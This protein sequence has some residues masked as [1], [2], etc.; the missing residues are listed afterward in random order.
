M[1]R[2]H[3]GDGRRWGWVEPSN[4]R[5]GGCHGL[6]GVRSNSREQQRALIQRLS[7]A[8]WRQHTPT[9]CEKVRETSQATQADT[10]LSHTEFFLS[11]SCSATLRPRK[12]GAR[13]QALFLSRL[14]TELACWL[15]SAQL[16]LPLLHSTHSDLSRTQ[17][18]SSHCHTSH[19]PRAPNR[20]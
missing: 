3:G 1:P 15:V 14:E 5:S 19:Y 7:S 6:G 9:A 18:W 10:P 2:G 20:V 16:L 17:I 8:N 13:S 11:P 12:P 4:Q